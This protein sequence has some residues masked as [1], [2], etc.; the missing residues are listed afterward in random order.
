ME[1]ELIKR[2]SQ[3]MQSD[4]NEMHNLGEELFMMNYV[5]QDDIDKLHEEF[6][7]KPI[8][9]RY[10]EIEIQETIKDMDNLLDIL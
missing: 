10:E 6:G 3:M 7:H 9:R 5:G 2:I 1:R 4:E 8:G